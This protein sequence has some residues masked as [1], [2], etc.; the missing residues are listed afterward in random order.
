MKKLMMECRNPSIILI[1][2]TISFLNTNCEREKNTVPFYVDIVYPTGGLGDQGFVDNIF[3]GVV[4][5]KYEHN[6][7]LY[8][9][10]PE[11]DFQSK[12]IIDSLLI[13]NTDSR[14]LLILADG[15]Y[16]SILDDTEMDL[17]SSNVLLLDGTTNKNIKRIEFSFYGA[18]YLAGIAA[19]GI[20]MHDTVAFVAGMPLPSLNICYNG[21]SDGFLSGGGAYVSRFFLDTTAM[22]FDMIDEAEYLTN[23]LLQTTDLV[24]GAAGG[25]NM[26][27]FNAIRTKEDVFVIGVDTD[28]SQFIT[29][30]VI[31]SVIKR[32]DKVIESELDDFAC[33]KY[34]P[35]RINYGLKSGYMDF[36]I[37]PGFNAQLSG[38]VESFREEALEKETLELEKYLD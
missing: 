4:T 18:A 30:S 20:T 35:S 7:P 37:N 5:A 17:S 27:I 24:F 32:I 11:N 15:T 9:F 29:G 2:I 10:F 38:L 8:H 1:L 21:F 16:G 26:G 22:G 25:A 6:F 28:Q 34:A 12:N 13:G 33:G 31:G 36:I 23:E 19:A 14:R 3:T